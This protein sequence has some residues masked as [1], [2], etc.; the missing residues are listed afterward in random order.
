MI[1]YTRFGDLF[2]VYTEISRDMGPH[3]FFSLNSCNGETIIS[4]PYAEIILTP[5][6]ILKAEKR[7][8]E[9]ENGTR[10]L[11]EPAARAP[12]DRL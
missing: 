10:T 1:G 2:A 6:E 3:P 5:G 7:G 4:L 9:N 8:R 12:E 11:S